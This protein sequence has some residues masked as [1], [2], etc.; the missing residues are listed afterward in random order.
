MTL[1]PVGSSLSVSP[2]RAQQLEQLDVPDLSSQVLS[3]RD[4]FQASTSA[5]VTVPAVAQAS[6]T[7]AVPS[8]AS[9]RV[10]TEAVLLAIESNRD[11]GVGTMSQVA[12][13]TAIAQF[14]AMPEFQNA[15]GTIDHARV[16]DYAIACCANVF[17]GQ[18]AVLS[19][20]DR[21]PGS[22]GSFRAI[23][24][25]MPQLD[26]S[27]IHGGD[28]AGWRASLDAT[29]GSTLRADLDDGSGGQARHTWVFI[30][31]GYAAPANALSQTAL[32]AGNWAHEYLDGGGTRQDFAASIGGGALGMS[33]RFLR[34]QIATQPETY[35]VEMVANVGSVVNAFFTGEGHPA[36]NTIYDEAMVMV[37]N[38]PAYWD[39]WRGLPWADTGRSSTLEP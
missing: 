22:S 23:L 2:A 14:S 7:T 3:W 34:D 20:M 24:D 13:D 17:T 15:D 8:E 36:G 9:L 33:L 16:M 31:M 26:G 21:I 39:A 12:L 11:A 28:V 35:D 6:E 32:F 30:A 29:N 25:S 18:D 10:A 27:M 37:R 1:R 4:T 19:G 5:A 38:I